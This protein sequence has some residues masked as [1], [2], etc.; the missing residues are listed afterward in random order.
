MRYAA[1]MIMRFITGTGQ[2]FSICYS[3]DEHVRYCR[4]RAAFQHR[5]SKSSKSLKDMLLPSPQPAAPQGK[6]PAS[7]VQRLWLFDN[8]PV[9]SMTLRQLRDSVQ[10][11]QVKLSSY[12]SFDCK[13]DP[14]LRSTGTPCAWWK[15]WTPPCSWRQWTPSSTASGCW[16]RRP[17]R[18][19]S[20]TTK[21]GSLPFN[22]QK[23]F[24]FTR[25]CCWNR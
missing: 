9:K 2:L 7:P 21:V 16:G 22:M 4:Y 11:L 6:A 25:P 17:G 18:S 20:W 24:N 1:F 10:N 12:P 14:G 13:A 8:V 19:A 23:S 15:P 5:F 3:I